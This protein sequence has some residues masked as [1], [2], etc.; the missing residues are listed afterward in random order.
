MTPK[1]KPL[2]E[3]VVLIT[4]A[5]S[6]IGLATA[7]MAAKRGAKVMLVARNEEA[8]AKIVSDLGADGGTAA[9]AIADV[10]DAA[11]VDAAAAQA[12]E[13]FGRIDTWVNNAG[14]AIYAPLLETPD[15]EHMRMFRTNYFGMVHGCLAAVRH[16]RDKGGALITVASIAADTPSP[17]LGAYTASKHA[18]KGYFESLRIEVT[19][20]G[21][22]ISMS[23][24]KPGGMATPIGEHAANHLDGEA[25]IP[26]P[27]YDAAITAEAIL[28]CAEHPRRTI[29]VGGAGRA[30][31]LFAEHFP[32]LFDR[33]A[34]L[35][36]PMLSS[37]TIPKT[38]GDALDAPASD[39][40][41]RPAHEHGRS[42]SI[43][44]KAN[45]HPGFTAAVALGVVAAGA[46]AL[47]GRRSA[48]T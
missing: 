38:P 30:Q 21:L 35:I 34:P 13:R 3:Q 16:L 45:L 29:T 47:F 46:F 11:A 2:A 33:L 41:V 12:V 9:F 17:I 27:V 22:P 25:M 19:N 6:G 36:I 24:V 44:T 37:K 5:S 18:V 4:G 48:S 7:Q 20:A 8:L 14:V 1:L 40:T 23:L 42:F 39:G 32:A 15:D 26:P 43:Y 28:H 31:S 10:G